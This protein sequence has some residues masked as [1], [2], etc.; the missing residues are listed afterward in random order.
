MKC[1]LERKWLI[2]VPSVGKQ[3]K[4]KTEKFSVVMKFI[5]TRFNLLKIRNDTKSDPQKT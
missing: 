5:K 2:V 1:T 3:S 4:L